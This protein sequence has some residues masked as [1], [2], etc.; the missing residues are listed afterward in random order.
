MAHPQPQDVGSCCGAAGL[1][2]R[3]GQ[4]QHAVL[5]DRATG[6]QAD[7]PPP[8]DEVTLNLVIANGR[9]WTAFSSD[10]G[11]AKAATTEVR[12][13]SNG[14]KARWF[15]SAVVGSGHVQLLACPAG[16]GPGSPSAPGY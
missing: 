8:G 2:G 9:D 14:E 4:P 3:A 10:V 6:R 15:D 16:S 13:F 7:T 1:R 5:R 12:S 11:I